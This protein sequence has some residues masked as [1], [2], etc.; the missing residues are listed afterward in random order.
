MNWQPI[1]TIPKDYDVLLAGVMDHENDWRIKVGHRD[2]QSGM[3]RI[4]GA[5]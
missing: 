3:F 5:R 1:N 4:Y 2:S